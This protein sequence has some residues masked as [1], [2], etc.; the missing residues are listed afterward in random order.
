MKADKE[1]TYEAYRSLYNP[2]MTIVKW[3]SS[4]RGSL[5]GKTG[6]VLLDHGS[7]SLLFFDSQLVHHTGILL[8][9]ILPLFVLHA[10]D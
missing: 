10:H 5:P 4:N 3:I 2:M 7:R 6:R 8:N 9:G 1:M